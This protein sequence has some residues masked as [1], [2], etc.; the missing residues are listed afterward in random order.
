MRLPTSGNRSDA[1]FN[2]TP[3]IDVVFLL[4]IFF[5]VSSHLARRE[6]RIHLN[7]P[8][9]QTGNRD[10][11]EDATLTLSV[12]SSGQVQLGDR[13]LD[14]KTL[15]QTLRHHFDRYGGIGIVRIRGDR[16]VAYQHISRLLKQ[17][18]DTGFANV[19]IATMREARP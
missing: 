11:G 18:A 9:A 10:E 8:A 4:I 14:E 13:I 15:L 7:L 5:L 6:T 12:M 16:A 19:S 3:M 1:T 17:T 2:M